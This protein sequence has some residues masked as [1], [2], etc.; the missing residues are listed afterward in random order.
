MA[1]RPAGPQHTG[2]PIQDGAVGGVVEVP[3]RGGPVQDPVEA[4][5]PRQLAH[6]PGDVVG[7]DPGGGRVGAGPVQEDGR[8]VKASDLAA[9]SG[10]PVGQLPVP[11]RQI[12]H[13]H[14]RPQLGQPPG[15]L[16]GSLTRKISARNDRPVRG[17]V[18]AVIRR[19]EK[20]QII[21]V[22][23]RG[24]VEQVAHASEQ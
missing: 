5:G 22:V 8:G 17:Q 3:K 11:A 9:A 13:A 2:D 21:L 4:A 1:S 20:V 19:G 24:S 7:A 23:H 15:Q 14:A 10:Q 6:V 18:A 12:Q 16:T